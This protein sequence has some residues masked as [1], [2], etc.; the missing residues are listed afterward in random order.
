[1]MINNA[2]GSLMEVWPRHRHRPFFIGVP[3]ADSV[4]WLKDI[5]GFALKKSVSGRAYRPVKVTNIV[6][7]S[8][9]P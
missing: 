7:T 8:P 2:I 9:F 6:P 1:M 4:R 3:T 5:G